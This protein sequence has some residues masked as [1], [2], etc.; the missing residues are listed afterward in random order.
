MNKMET[1]FRNLQGALSKLKQFAA[2]NT[3]KEI[4][5]AGVLQAFKVSFS[6]CS[7]SFY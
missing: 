1:K 7:R 2:E 6:G 3:G 5:E 4:E